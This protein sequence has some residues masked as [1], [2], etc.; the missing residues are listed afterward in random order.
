MRPNSSNN[1]FSSQIRC[2]S[3]LYL[4]ATFSLLNSAQPPHPYRHHE[5]QYNVERFSVVPKLPREL[6]IRNLL[7][8]RLVVSAGESVLSDRTGEKGVRWG[9]HFLRNSN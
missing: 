4:L 5:V 1:G 3:V 7:N 9:F 2:P 6:F 8:E